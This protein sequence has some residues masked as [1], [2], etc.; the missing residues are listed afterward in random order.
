MSHS[1][2][3]AVCYLDRKSC[4]EIVIGLSQE[5]SRLSIDNRVISGECSSFLVHQDTLLFT[6]GS[7]GMYHSLYTF[8]LLSDSLL[9]TIDSNIVQ[10]MATLSAQCKVQCISQRN[11]EKG[12]R[13]VAVSGQRL[14]MQIVPRGNLETIN[15]RLLMF[16]HIHSLIQK[17]DYHTAFSLLRTHKLDM[18]LLFDLDPQYFLDHTQEVA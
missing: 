16:T 11:V 17:R 7:T 12:S 2:K 3:R 15:P 10:V 9:H 4:R 13:L 6:S 5:K 1:L 18:N 14:V 8:S